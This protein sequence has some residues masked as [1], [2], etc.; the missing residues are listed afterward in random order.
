MKSQFLPICVSENT[1]KPFWSSNRGLRPWILFLVHFR[2][3][4]VW[5]NFS[6]MR[7]RYP[8]ILCLV[9]SIT[10]SN[11]KR[12][13]KWIKKFLTINFD[14]FESLHFLNL[15]G[16]SSQKNLARVNFWSIYAR[17]YLKEWSS[18]NDPETRNLFLIHLR[19]TSL[20]SIMFWIMR[21]FRF[22]PQFDPLIVRLGSKDGILLRYQKVRTTALV[23]SESIP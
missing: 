3:N 23:L 10:F 20:A 2:V 12:L 7:S 9:R 17:K 5:I 19:D 14:P 4:I 1:R 11:K 22:D 8:L 13:K 18:N 15:D 6:F 21:S 16:I